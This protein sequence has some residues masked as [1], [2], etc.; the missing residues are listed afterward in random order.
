MREE[1]SKEYLA[2][3]DAGLNG[4]NEVNCHFGLFST[5]ERTKEWERGNKDGLGDKATKVLK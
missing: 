1:A 2:G 4:P 3:Y 5:L